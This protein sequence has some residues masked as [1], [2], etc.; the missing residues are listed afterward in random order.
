MTI[1]FRLAAVSRA[2]AHESVSG[3]AL[4]AGFTGSPL[5]GN[6]VSPLRTTSS[7]ARNLLQGAGLCAL[8][9]LLFALGFVL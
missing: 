4:R 1:K 6:N 9:W 8:A 5:Y 3:E 7:P 2:R